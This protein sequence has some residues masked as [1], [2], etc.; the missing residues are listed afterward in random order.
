M[1]KVKCSDSEGISTAGQNSKA[2]GKGFVALLFSVLAIIACLFYIGPKL[3]KLPLFQPMAR[4]IE[5]RGI[6]ANVYFYTE[7]E[8]FSEANVH[9]QNSMDYLDKKF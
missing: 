2:K 3:E 9:L 6:E 4:F 5:E 1:E 8:E 7:V